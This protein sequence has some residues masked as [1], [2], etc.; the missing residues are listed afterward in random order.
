MTDGIL[1]PFDSIVLAGG[2][3]SRM[4]PLT[5]TLPKPMLPVC[6][7]SAFSR[8]IKL[9]RKNDFLS[10][11]VTTMYLPEKVE[12]FREIGNKGRLTF[13][14]ETSPVGSAGALGRLK[15][16]VAKTFLVISG[17]AVCG[18]DLG[19]IR[20]D[21][22]NSNEK[23]LMILKKQND[24]SEFGSV[25][26]KDGFIR[27][28]REKPSP[29]DIVSN[30]ANTGIYMFSDEIL[31]FIPE[32]RF[33]DFS[34]DLFPL[35]MK[36]G[37]KISARIEDGFWYD[38]GSFSEYYRCCMR[39]SGNENCIGRNVSVSENAKIEKSIIFDSAVIKDAVIIKSV[40][41]RNAKIEKG[42]LISPGCVIGDGAVLDRD[43]FLPPETIV[44]TG[45]HIVS[46]ENASPFGAYPKGIS[47][48][49]DGA[50]AECSDFALQKLGSALAFLGNIGVACGI[51]SEDY[52]RCDELCTGIRNF[53]SDCRTFFGIPKVLC[54]FIASEFSLSLVVFVSASDGKA[55]L[56]FYDP[57]GMTVHRG[58]MREIQ[59]SLKSQKLL[60]FSSETPEKSGVLYPVSA[61]E[62]TAK[63]CAFIAKMLP[64][65]KFPVL[66]LSEPCGKENAHSFVSECASV[67]KIPIKNSE[68]SFFVSES[69]EKCIGMTESGI[70]IS[71]SELFCIC[72]ILGNIKEVF[73]P[74][75]CE[76]AV[77]N[78]LKE[79]GIKINFFDDSESE[80]R[81]RAMEFP[82]YF[83]G[84][85]LCFS[86]ICLLESHGLSLSDALTLIPE[87]KTVSKT[88]FV[89]EEA[90]AEI[91]SRLY[92]ESPENA[93]SAGFY[94]GAGRSHFIPHAGGKIEI[95][96]EA[97]NY[98]L[99]EEFSL[100]TVKK[101]EEKYLR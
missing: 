92:N 46:G 79:H 17:D 47:F 11:A 77:E 2:F 35:L 12:S 43:V 8:I 15:G 24:V 101:I 14:R 28:F 7:E 74:R 75:F 21:F 80:E 9:L 67:L 71:H 4:A 94:F 64:R 41:G 19:K 89:G 63:Y 16:Q 37:I 31:D 93:R 3:G 88:V 72:C 49:D 38:I 56:T 100:E 96:T 81:K 91:I 50:E 32:N 68:N 83:D 61:S 58:K 85:M 26:V 76:A 59:K 18:F 86:I 95:L 1:K 22:E 97:S 42:C 34:K 99:A 33:F 44:N 60:S 5:D 70:K 45:E 69:G 78:I 73:L 65:S 84:I 23:A 36:K 52:L 30:L 51:G 66:S 48:L 98:E 90:E 53:G 29:R 27:K 55:T 82:I 39:F 13:F 57:S 40:V 20:K 10:T 87:F 54:R 6:G 62:I 25:S